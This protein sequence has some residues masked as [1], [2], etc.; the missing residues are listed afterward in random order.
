MRLHLL[1]TGLRPSSLHL[2][3]LPLPR[4]LRHLG[5]LSENPGTSSPLHSH[6]QGPTQDKAS[7]PHDT[8]AAAGPSLA[9]GPGYIPQSGPSSQVLMGFSSAGGSQLTAQTLT[10][11]SGLA[12]P[13]TARQGPEDP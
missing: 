9:P 4:A 1:R 8:A 6:P 10:N 5:P 7:A 3:R 11:P 13:R 12:F 2:Q